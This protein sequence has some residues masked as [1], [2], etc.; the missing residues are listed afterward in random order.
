VYFQGFITERK[1]RRGV[2]IC[3]LWLCDHSWLIEVGPPHGVQLNVKRKIF[4]PTDSNKN[5]WE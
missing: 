5:E 2:L 3:C 4:M 1:D